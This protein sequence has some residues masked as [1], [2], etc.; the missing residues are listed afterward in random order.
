MG[1]RIK[2][3]VLLAFIIASSVGCVVQLYAQSVHVEAVSTLFT[4]A[5]PT[6]I[7]LVFQVLNDGLNTTEYSFESSVPQNW[8]VISS[9]LPLVLEPGAA[10]TV[11][12]LLRI[13]SGAPSGPHTVELKVYGSASENLLSQAA[14]TVEVLAGISARISADRLHSGVVPG[15]TAEY[16]ITLTNSGNT[17]ATFEFLAES[18]WPASLAPTSIFLVP[19]EQFLFLLRHHVPSD[20]DPGVTDLLMVTVRTEVAR[21]DTG[22]VSVV[23]KALPPTPEAVRTSLFQSLPAR[24]RFGVLHNVAD[25]AFAGDFSFSL[26]GNVGSGFFA[27]VFRATSLFGPGPA[28]LESFYTDYRTRGT[29][30]RIGDI[31]SP[32]TDL[33]NLSCRGGS[34]VVAGEWHNLVFIAGGEEDE[35]RVG[36]RAL[37]GPELLT[38]GAGYV[39][40]RSDSSRDAIW[41]VLGRMQPFEPLRFR[42]EGA[43]GLADSKISRAY[44]LNSTMN[45]D[46]MHSSIDVFSIG[47]WFPGSVSDQAGLNLDFSF[48]LPHFSFS[49]SLNHVRDNVYRDPLEPTRIRDQGDLKLSS[50]PLKSGPTLDSEISLSWFRDVTRTS[51]DLVARRLSIGMRD[52]GGVFRYELSSTLSDQIDRIAASEIR[53]LTFREGFGIERGVFEAYLLLTQDR[54]IDLASLTRLSG[55]TS[56]RFQ[57]QARNSPYSADLHLTSTRDEFDLGVTLQAALTE[58]LRLDLGGSFEWT[59]DE[60]PPTRFVWQAAVEYRFEL[61]VPFLVTLGQIEG[62]AF[63]DINENGRQDE[64]EPGVEGVGLSASR[65]EAISDATGRFRLPPMRPGSYDISGLSFPADL[66]P[67]IAVPIL[68]D[69]SV[70]QTT[71]VHIPFARACSIAGIVIVRYEEPVNDAI[72]INGGSSLLDTSVEGTP[73]SGIAV[74][75]VGSGGAL[76]QRSDALG[77][78]HFDALPPGEWR[79]WIDETQLDRFH[80]ID[81]GTVAV[82]LPQG[83]ECNIQFDVVAIRQTVEIL[84]EGSI[85][86]RTEYDSNPP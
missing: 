25:A 31:S 82:T 35:T 20:V 71:I 65:V 50:Q 44:F 77:E 69:V 40:R 33:T 72:T 76:T 59:R 79:I 85:T 86:L 75:A 16:T 37:I 63:V 53:T 62:I 49:A 80:R 56:V 34:I 52:T 29:T 39:E 83:E 4:V 45:F 14:L 41:S 43:L 57:L 47:S 51:E 5:P 66:V 30:Y 36:A 22:R 15:G 26:L 18:R 74:Q 3:S 13:P 84:E 61:P 23:T 78:F 21:L 17:P 32:L 27:S 10:D 24:V 81:A 46:S 12:L 58:T 60:A 54:V 67:L 6:L 2:H 68:V 11:L 7:T 19:G 48:G 73:L 1:N 70:K 42:I 64:G 9:P 28:Q 38:L 8:A 55:G